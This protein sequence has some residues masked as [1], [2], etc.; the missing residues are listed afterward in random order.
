MADSGTIFLNHVDSLNQ[1]NQ[2][3]LLNY[4][5]EG[6][7]NRVNG[8][9]KVFSNARIVAS[10]SEGIASSVEQ[11]KFDK[12]L[13]NI[14]GKNAYQLKALRNQKR[15][16]PMLTKHLL[17][18]FSREL[19]KDVKNVSDDAMG[20]LMSYDWPGNVI[21]LENVLRRAV[22]L[23][24][25]NTIT[26]EHI[27]FG[28]PT[29]EKKWSFDMLSVN[30]IKGFLKSR[31]Y[32]QGIRVISVIFL[33]A[34][35]CILFTGHKDGL[36][37][38]A[39]IFLW[40]AGLFGVYLITLISG[41]SLCGVCPFAAAGDWIQRLQCFNFRIPNVFLVYGRYITIG[42]ILLIFWL[43]GVTIMPR[44]SILTAFL[45]ISI[46]SGAVISGIL[47]ER[48]VWC[49]Y[50]CPL[51][52]LLGTYSLSSFTSLKSN[53]SVCLNQCETHDCYVG[54]KSIKG[55]PMFLHPYA[56]ESSRDCVLCMN[57]YKNCDHSSI[58]LNLQLPGRDIAELSDRSLADSFLSLS[59]LG[60]LLV[61][62]ESLLSIDSVWFQ[63]LYNLAGI[64]QS[65]LYTLVF[66]FV[67]VAPFIL[68]GFFN[69]I[70]SGFSFGKMKIK[71][72]DFGYA[73]IPLALMGHLAFYW[74]KLKVNFWR[75]LEITNIYTSGR[76][77]NEG[78]IIN[79]IENIS[80][81]ELLFILVGFIGSI[82]VFFLVSKR[83]GHTITKSD[84]ACNF[85]IFT[86]FAF[87]YMYICIY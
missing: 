67:S 78:L 50:I 34:V 14:L 53:R 66:I 74:D 7:F 35:L 42:M 61:E 48:R 84:I 40:S 26:T 38:F 70:C 39:N 73:A 64:N 11:G 57:C 54:T 85:T 3:K 4:I 51:G 46:L 43:E 60:V 72:A 25:G 69:L 52:G 31:F 56:L 6:R 49:R 58:K 86:F 44:S 41:R 36:L 20:R 21:E 10:V 63:L 33:I 19:H 68:T 28:I 77:E 23:A 27:F 29:E 16:I 1:A 81:L 45:L 65:V 76:I 2:I 71:L 87:I 5:Q 47:Y 24:E 9:D 82:Y 17:E 15:S 30:A 79:K 59:L 8:S 12:N 83:S 18:K 62:Y 80:A 32:P 55:C 75:L 13:Y 22:L 37:N